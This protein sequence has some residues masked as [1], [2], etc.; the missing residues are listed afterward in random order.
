MYDCDKG[1]I[2]SER[3]PV[4]AT[5]V[6]GLWRPRELPEC[7]PAIHPRLRWNRRK[8]EAADVTPYKTPMLYRQF[9]RN[10]NGILHNQI[11]NGTSLQAAIA[12]QMTLDNY[13]RHRRIATSQAI[14]RF[15]KR[16]KQKQI[17]T[18]END[19]KIRVD[20]ASLMRKHSLNPN[21]PNDISYHTNNAR[22]R[23]QINSLDHSKIEYRIYPNTYN[24]NAKIHDKSNE[25]LADTSRIHRMRNVKPY[26]RLMRAKRSVKQQDE[27]DSSGS[28]SE[29]NSKR[30]RSR[31]PCEVL[32]L[33]K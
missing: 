9:K 19:P 3:G 1:Y 25:W 11:D 13:I 18:G 33:F 29:T 8:R 27:E 2:L 5:C 32:L 6:G 22:K 26:E 21:E 24:S 20:I 31:E 30:S 12:K 7:S 15:R 4:G 16:M 23:Q 17:A 10:I 28:D 14:L